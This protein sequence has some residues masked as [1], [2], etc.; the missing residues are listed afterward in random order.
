MKKKSFFYGFITA[1]SC[2]AYVK[3]WNTEAGEGICGSRT[4]GGADFGILG[5]MFVDAACV[6]SIYEYTGQ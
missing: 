2:F 6:H 5:K 3:L 4:A 1:G